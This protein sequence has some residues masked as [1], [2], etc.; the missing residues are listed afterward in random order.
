MSERLEERA[1]NK[2]RRERAGES[3]GHGGSAPSYR[4]IARR[5]PGILY[6]CEHDP[7]GAIRYR[8]FSPRIE[9]VTGFSPESFY[10]DPEMIFTRFHPEDLSAYREKMRF[11]LG[12]RVERDWGFE[13]RLRHREGNYI[14]LASHATRSYA[15]DGSV[16]TWGVF[17][18]ITSRKTSEQDRR[19]SELQLRESQRRLATLIS[20]LAGM[21]YRCGT[22]KRRT[23]QF[24]SRGC[25]SLTGYPPADLHYNRKVAY[26]E[27]VHPEDR[28]RV[29]AELEAALT[30]WRPYAISYRIITER[31]VEK[32]VL[33][34]GQGIAGA[35]G[36]LAALEGF[37]QDIGERERVAADFGSA[38]DGAAGA[39]TRLVAEPPAGSSCASSADRARRE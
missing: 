10:E 34:Q 28:E 37:A 33:D 2:L 22:D 26:H 25:E 32:R 27:L 12:A 7:D 39:S 14:W 11:T 23:M 4:W 9:E 18:D 13:F 3:A 21:V 36:S 15:E 38:E 19:M 8:Y 6:N 17:L 1:V 30:E 5:L 31:G 20:N 29:S 16:D 24:V 35:D